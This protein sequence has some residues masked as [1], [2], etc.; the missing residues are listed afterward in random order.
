MKY[1]TNIHEGIT[2]SYTLGRGGLPGNNDS[3][4][5]SSCFIW[6]VLGLFPASG[7]GEFLLGSPHVEK[8]IIRLSNQN[9]LIIEAK[10]FDHGAYRVDKVELN[11]ERIETYRIRI[12]EVMRGGTLTFFMK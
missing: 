12:A 6:N 7:T 2:K 11:G 4:G 3:G 10:N 8:A 1:K 5:L 9:S